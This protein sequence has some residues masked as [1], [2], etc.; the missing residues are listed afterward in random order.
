MIIMINDSG[1]QNGKN[2]RV[3]QLHRPRRGGQV[4]RQRLVVRERAVPP[5][6]VRRRLA[7]K[8]GLRVG[9]R[10]EGCVGRVE[11]ERVLRHAW[12]WW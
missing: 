3:V 12:W 10:D 8:V 11:R 5:H 6:D 7:G 1:G 2:G 9:G 4:R